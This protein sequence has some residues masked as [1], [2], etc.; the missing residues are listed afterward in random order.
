MPC[1]KATGHD[2]IIVKAFKDN[3]DNL[4]GVLT[5]IINNWISRGTYPDIL[6]IA[7]VPPNQF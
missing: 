2:G 6:K 4:V 5:K 3:M 1:Y 7:R